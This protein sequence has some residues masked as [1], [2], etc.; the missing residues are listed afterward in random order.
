MPDKKDSPQY[1]AQQVRADRR[2]NN[3]KYTDA[4]WHTSKAVSIST[5]IGMLAL[6]VTGLMTFRD[7][8]EEIRVMEERTT[9]ISIAMDAR[10]T[11]RMDA[12]VTLIETSTADRISRTTVDAMFQVKD[13]QIETL[14]ESMNKLSAKMDKTND[15]LTQ[16]MR[17][18]KT[19]N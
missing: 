13:M 2:N 19:K 17:S 5:I 3:V 9:Q 8:T 7:F 15:L 14:T 1:V 10:H 18:N 12:L 16:L 4:H 6:L 11:A